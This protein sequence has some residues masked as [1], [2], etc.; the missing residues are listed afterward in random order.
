MRIIAQSGN[1][2]DNFGARGQGSRSDF[3][4]P[5]VH[6]DRYAQLAPQT[7]EHGPNAR[8]LVLSGNSE[9]SGPS[10]FAAHIQDIRAMSFQLQGVRDSVLRM[11]IGA[12]VGKAVRGDVQHAHDERAFTEKQ[13]ARAEAKMKTP[14]A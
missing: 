4:F 3:G 7:F 9:G 5:R 14:A 8:Q 2:V 1:V 12:A 13:C 11:E 6:G 10:G